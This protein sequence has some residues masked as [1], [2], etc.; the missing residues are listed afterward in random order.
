MLKSLKQNNFHIPVLTYAVKLTR[1][2][3]L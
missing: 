1:L 3:N 2:E